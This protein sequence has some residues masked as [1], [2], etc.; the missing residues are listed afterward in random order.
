[1]VISASLHRIKLSVGFGWLGQQRIYLRTQQMPFQYGT[2]LYLMGFLTMEHP[3]VSNQSA[4]EDY[5]RDKWYNHMD[6]IVAQDT[7]DAEFLAHIQRLKDADLIVDDTLTLPI[8]VERSTTRVEC[9]GKKPFDVPVFQVYVPRRY[10]D[11]ANYLNDRALLVTR[12]LKTLV[13][14]SIVKNNP[15]AY[16]PQMVAHAKFLFEHPSIT[17][18]RVSQTDY[19]TTLPDTNIA[20]NIQPASLRAALRSQHFFTKVHENM[21]KQTVMVS[22]TYATYDEGCKWIDSILRRY[23]YHPARVR[24]L[25]GWRDSSWKQVRQYLSVVCRYTPHRGYVI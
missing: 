22:L 24:N 19:E 12:T 23:P 13:P 2:D 15:K 25:A 1:M 7:N 3:S 21:E 11:A 8:S 9:P 10:R 18:A 16:Y 5:V 17:I 4:V 14:F 6:S 20:D